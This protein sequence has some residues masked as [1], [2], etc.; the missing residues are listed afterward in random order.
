MSSYLTPIDY[1]LWVV[2]TVI[3]VVLF[4]RLTAGWLKPIKYFMLYAAVRDVIL[5]ALT[6]K[7][8]EYQYFIVQ[9]LGQMV[10]LIWFAYIAKTIINR[11]ALNTPVLLKWLPVGV[12][13]TL[14]GISTS[15]LYHL[16]IQSTPQLLIMQ[17]HCALVSIIAISTA[18]IVKLNRMYSNIILA[19]LGLIGTGITTAWVWNYLGYQPVISELL[20]IFGLI[21][22]GLA[23]KQS[24]LPLLPLEQKL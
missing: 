11:L 12:V 21:G 17:T 15:Y 9:W 18:V 23:A 1:L 7:S 19:I 22:V 5:L 14:C 10:S 6:P 16:S 24:A 8:F 2:F 20:W 3:E 4:I 13:S